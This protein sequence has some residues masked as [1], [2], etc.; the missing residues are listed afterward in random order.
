LPL[1]GGREREMHALPTVNAECQQVYT[2]LLDDVPMVLQT[3][4]YRNKTTVDKQLRLLS[5]TEF[6]GHDTFHQ[7]VC[8]DRIAILSYETA[9]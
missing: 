7:Q 6:S 1:P 8:P 2:E 4:L 3:A 9:T 5:F